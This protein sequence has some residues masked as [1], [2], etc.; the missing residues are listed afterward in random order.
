MRNNIYYNERKKSISQFLG[1]IKMKK[2]KNPR[3]EKVKKK[4]AKNA[5]KAPLKKHV[6]EDDKI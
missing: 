1:H 6:H 2:Q 5:E 3:R 4:W